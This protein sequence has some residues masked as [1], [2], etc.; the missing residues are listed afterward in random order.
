M[1]TTLDLRPYQLVIVIGVDHKI[2]HFIPGIAPNDPRTRLRLRFHAFLR[3]I[4]R[5]YPVDVI[6]EEAKH[7]VESIAEMLAHREGL[8]YRNVEMTPERRTELGIPLMYPIDVPASEFP[9][10]QKAKWNALRESH[11]V[12]ELLEA[13]AGARTAVVICGVS[14]LRSL[15]RALQSKFW[16]VERYDVSAMPWFDPSLL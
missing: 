3:E 8:R 15:G 6:C 9:P 10:Q 11:M 4:T 7:G 14:H 1:E 12:D 5:R 16:R 2:Q 13:N